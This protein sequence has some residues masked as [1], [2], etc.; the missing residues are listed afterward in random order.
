MMSDSVV[1]PA[2]CLTHT[3]SLTLSLPFSLYLA[4]NH[5]A[6]RTVVDVLRLPG[7]V[8][9]TE[10]AA[11][12]ALLLHGALHGGIGRLC[13][14]SGKTTLSLFRSLSKFVCGK[15]S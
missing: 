7:Q 15:K 9:H 10:T 1:L 4:V 8:S 14:A 11:M 2:L 12:S 3:Q 5:G 6:I 13:E